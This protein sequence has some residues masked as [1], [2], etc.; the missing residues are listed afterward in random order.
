[1]KK[2]PIGLRPR[3]IVDTDRYYEMRRAIIDYVSCA[4]PL[5]VEWITEYNEIC[6]RNIFHEDGN[7]LT[8]KD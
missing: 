6:S 7:Y 4:Q 1:M 2:P 3:M 5:P 8:T